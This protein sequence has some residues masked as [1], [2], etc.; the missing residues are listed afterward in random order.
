MSSG[1]THL[2]STRRF[3]P[4]FLTQALGAFNDNIFKQALV[5][6]LSYGLAERMG[7]NPQ[8]MVTA[9]AG[10]FILPFFLFS[11]TAGQ[12]AERFEKSQLIRYVKLAEIGLCVIA[13]IGL[14]TDNLYVL[15]ATLFFLG[16]QSTFFGPLKYSILPD[17]LQTDEL[18]AGN[19][20]I[21]MGTFLSI[22]LGII[23]GGVFI[24]LPYG[25]WIISGI[26]LTA[27]ISGYW[28]SCKIPRATIAAPG[29]KISPNFIA[30]TFQMLA[31]TRKHRTVFLSVMGISWFWFLG[32][33]YLSQ[34]PSFSNHTLHANADI[35]TLFNVAFSVGV[36]LG[37]LLCHRLLQGDIS[38]RYVPLSALGMTVFGVDLYFAANNIVIPTDTALLTLSQ[39][40][41]LSAAWRI[42]FDLTALSICG[43]LYIVPLYAIV[44]H[45]SEA[46]HRSRTIAGLNIMNALFMVGS[47]LFTLILL[48]MNY[49]VNHVFLIIALLNTIVAIYICKL[50]PADA[51]ASLARFIL[52][53]LFRVEVRGIEHYRRVKDKAVI[54]LNHASF[55][56]GLLIAVFLPEMPTLVMNT[57]IA[58]RWWAKP[59]LYVARI[60]TVDSTSPMAVKTMVRYVQAGHK[61]VI[62]P[63]GRITVTGALMK[64]YEGPGTVAYFADAP[65]L[66][67]RIDGAQYTIFSRARKVLPTHWFPKITL[68]IQEP[69]YFHVPSDM[70]GRVRRQFIGRKLYD[71][72]ADMIFKTSPIDQP[73]FK[74]LIQTS[75]IFSAN[76][77][78]LEDAA[79]VPRSYRQVFKSSFALGAYLK[80]RTSAQ[81]NVGVLLPNAAATAISFFALQAIGRTPAML[82][83]STGL[84]NMQAAC[85]MSNIKTIITSRRFI[86]MGKLQDTLN[87]LAERLQVIYL[88]DM[89]HALSLQHKLIGLC[90]AYAPDFIYHLL[91]DKIS[92]DD[93]AVILFT[94]GSEGV[95]KAVVLSHRNIQANRY[96]LLARIDFN[97][98]DLVFNA[99]PLFH[100]FG[101]TGGFLLPV[102]S[103]IRTF[104]YPSP[105]HYRIVPELVYETNATIMFGTDTFLSG[106]AKRAHPYDFYSLRY[107]FA[108]AERLKP[109]TSQHYTEKF[110]LRILEG[111]GATETAPV[112][113]ANT[114]MQCKLGTV[115]R[116][117]PGINHRLESVPGIHEGGRL[118]V[119]GPNIMKGYLKHDQPGVLQIPESGWYDTGDIVTIDDEGYVR[120]VGRA[121]RFAKIAGEMVSLSAVEQLISGAWPDKLHAVIAIPDQR[122][123]EQLVLI[124]NAIN[125]ERRDIAEILR[126][127]GA[128]ELMLPRHIVHVKQLPM[129]GTGKI[130]YMSLQKEVS[131]TL[132]PD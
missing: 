40:L 112:L 68:T 98:S 109:E 84:Q 43:G 9:A 31:Y 37:S 38:A 48:K 56:D 73:L 12:L 126:Q 119:Q 21:E 57:H 30:A 55:L 77:L 70:R 122:K 108:G 61:L 2:L 63:E 85:A 36:G 60:L 76:T 80:T 5:L 124:T 16:A 45:Y 96:Q 74:S 78:V 105:L 17:H 97:P 52:R 128:A 121:K 67:I 82:N 65:L 114:A 130:D 66:P 110:G 69:H 127:Q 22:L 100:S 18:V 116:F 102:L 113:C 94:S 42:L 75:K 27:S 28:I 32:I 49:S 29:L 120:I 64:V 47:A 10:L 13:T 4:L 26:L 117:L 91:N 71:L 33:T 44:Q 23:I 104:F 39:F 89:P 107:V 88:E 79:R 35:A 101:L 6:M 14:F 25:D 3:L 111:Y 131:T 54:V 34:F 106:Y 129:L 87:S 99:L 123:G 50:L 90:G 115:G 125:L 58:K 132:K 51:L 19:G 118:F 72:M 95:P 24:T 83:F 15:L 7:L 81:E 1:A 11:A 62:F 8:V 86:E 53:L 41:Q 103:G 92:A 20:L 93:A 46:S 59:A